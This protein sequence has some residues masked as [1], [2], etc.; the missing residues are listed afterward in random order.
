[1]IEFPPAVLAVFV[2]MIIL[3]TI[4]IAC[5]VID[6]VIKVKEHILYVSQWG[7]MPVENST[8]GT[9]EEQDD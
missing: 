3:S 1:M 8:L 9:S 2:T 5:C 7:E 4:G 6:T